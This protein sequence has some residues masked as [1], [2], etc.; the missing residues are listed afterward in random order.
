MKKLLIGIIPFLALVTVV[1][2]SDTSERK[3]NMT[4]YATYKFAVPTD[5]TR[6]YSVDNVLYDD[7]T[8][9]VCSIW[10]DN[11]LNDGVCN[12]TIFCVS[13]EG[14]LEQQ[15]D[16][17]GMVVPDT[18]IDGEMAYVST[19]HEVV[20]I[21]CDTGS[22]TQV[23]EIDSD[24][25][26]Y[27]VESIGEFYYVLLNGE[28]LKYTYNGDLEGRIT[29][30]HLT[31]YNYYCPIFESGNDIYAVIDDDDTKY[32]KLDF[33]SGIVEYYLS[34]RELG[35]TYNYYSGKYMF[36]DTGE[37]EID[38]DN[39]A[40]IKI[41]D[42]NNTNVIP[43][44]KETSLY[45]IPIDDNHFVK[46]YN[47]R[48]GQAE[49][50]LFNYD[51]TIDYSDATQLVIGGYN[52]KNDLAVAKAVYK[53]NSTHHDYRFVLEDYVENFVGEYTAQGVQDSKL[54]LL[55]YFNE[56][57]APDIFYGSDFDYNQFGDSGMVIDLMTYMNGEGDFNVNSIYGPIKDLVVH[58]GSCYSLFPGFY[59]NGYWGLSDVFNESEVSY[60]EL[61]NVDYDGSIYGNEYAYNI[62][63]GILSHN[64]QELYS[65]SG[66]GS[67]IDES[68]L[69]DIINYSVRNGMSATAPFDQLTLPSIE[70]IVSGNTLLSIMGGMDINSFKNMEQGI[71]KSLVYVGYP[72]L[73][74]SVHLASP[75]SQVAISAG[76][77]YPN[78]CWELISALM[79]NE[80]QDYIISVNRIPVTQDA[81]ED[82]LNYAANPAMVPDERVVLKS[83]FFA[84]TAV[85]EWI[86]VDYRSAIDSVDTLD[87]F[88]WGIY[89]IIQEEVSSYDTQNKTVDEIA[90][91]LQS[92][93]EVYISDNYSW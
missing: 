13:E 71:N 77:E 92:R 6:L 60:S 2:C 20:F 12:S 17:E 82:M 67:F 47:Y 19:T 32:Y 15:F 84:N 59:L 37:Y 63:S 24:C 79:S 88:D 72:S 14:E 78:E 64:L 18:I 1:G 86:V 25:D 54:E 68:S 4:G 85:P 87:V 8:Y 91:S 7:G 80:V 36:D 30:P 42:W 65:M 44:S 90:R 35:N 83:Y 28:I 74:G 41:A 76:T 5:E 3:A 73:S 53:Y 16:Y 33:N 89:A 38:F 51:N 11:R 52:V 48:D 34:S 45:F 9:Y 58:D 57:N 93:I 62:A 39:M 81:V 66:D 61:E 55:R 31:N 23:N 56:G 26:G 27:D 70:D 10:Y 40:L 22:L 21:D 29:D 46:P 69:A 43:P 49:V 75:V 50:I